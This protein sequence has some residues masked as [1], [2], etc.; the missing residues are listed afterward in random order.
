MFVQLVNPSNYI[1][2]IP[3]GVPSLSTPSDEK[4]DVDKLMDIPKFY[5]WISSSSAATW[6]IF[7]DCELRDHLCVHDEP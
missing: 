2:P 5:N 1:I 7:I 6:E 3:I 4:S